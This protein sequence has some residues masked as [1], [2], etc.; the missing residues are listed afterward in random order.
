MTETP[1]YEHL[2]RR[3]SVRRK[4]DF[5]WLKRLGDLTGEVCLAVNRDL[6]IDFVDDRLFDFLGMPPPADP[7]VHLNELTLMMAEQGFFG[8]GEPKVFEALI[9]DMLVNQRLKQSA[10]TQIINAVTPRGQHID[11]RV[12]LGRDDGYLILLR[13]NTQE[14]LERRVLNTALELGEAGYWAYNLRTR[15]YMIRAD[16]V[17]RFFKPETFDRYSR[18]GFID[19]THPD[20]KQTFKNALKAV[21]NQVKPVHLTVRLICD[22]GP[23]RHIRSHMMPHVDESGLVRSVSC[24]FT[25]VTQQVSNEDALNR[26]REEAESALSGKNEFLGRLSHEVRTPLNAVIGMADALVY[27]CHD[28]EVKPQL[29]LIQ[30]SAEKVMAMVD[31]TL[32]HTKLSDD[33]IVLNPRDCSPRTLIDTV[34]RSWV[35]RAKADNVTLAWKVHPEVPDTLHIDD[36]RYEQCLNNLLSNAIKFSGGGRVDVLLAPAGK[37]TNRKLVLAVRDTG[38][39]MTDEALTHIFDPFIQADKTISSRFGGTGLG[40]SI[41]KD[42][43]SLMGGDISVKSS[44]GKGTFFAISLPLAS[45]DVEASRSVS[46]SEAPLQGRGSVARHEL[47]SETALDAQGALPISATPNPVRPD[48]LVDS[49]LGK[50]VGKERSFSDL[51]VLIVDDNATNH[52]VASSLLSRVVKSIDTALNG[53]EA[54]DILAQ[55]PFDLVLMDIHMPVMDG[56]ETTLAIRSTPSPY[57]KVPIIALTADPQYQQA[58]LCRNIGMNASLGKPVKLTGLLEAFEDVLYGDAQT[59]QTIAA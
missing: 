58:R 31:S 10:A 49:L 54:L 1:H 9:A 40:L 50:S 21:I 14:E 28:E 20:D 30:N 56:I 17:E 48:T 29:R 13:D 23:V 18:E 44:P 38:I 57:Q 55:K 22:Y 47:P 19:T 25:D 45:G 51:R 46:E 34:C 52:I 5:F 36:Y 4:E 3:V 59:I 53:Q 41:V 35:E 24:F 42:L 7:P 43:V 16:S 33:A 37:G 11:I 6:R 12:S 2:D 15:D 8:Q 26:A 39:G 32:E 27:N